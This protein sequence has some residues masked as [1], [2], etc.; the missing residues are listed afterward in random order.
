MHKAIFKAIAEKENGKFYVQDSDI[1]LGGGVRSPNVIYL[2]KFDYKD[3]AFTILNTTGTSYQANITCNLSKS[4]QVIA[5]EI[6]SIS[7]L[8]NLF[9]RKKSRFNVKSDNENIIYFLKQN[10]AIKKLSAIA[11]AHNFSPWMTCDTEAKSIVS[12]YHLE[13]D[14]WTQVIAPTI[15]LYKNVIDEFEKRVA[16]LS[17]SQYRNRIR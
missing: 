3:C 5:F 16:H 10:K 6:T 4:L 11:Q 9:L 13:F 17:H 12:K 8:S 1:S 7:H 14:D 2:I 15:A